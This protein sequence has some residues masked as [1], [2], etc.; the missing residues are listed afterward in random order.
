MCRPNLAFGV[1]TLSLLPNGDILRNDLWIEAKQLGICRIDGY[2]HPMRV[3]IAE[4]LDAGKVFEGRL[5][6]SL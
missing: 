1:A 5:T 2:T 3:R 4:G 6:F